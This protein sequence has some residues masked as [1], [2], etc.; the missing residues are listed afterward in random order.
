MHNFNI[1]LLRWEVLPITWLSVRSLYKGNEK[2]GSL[3]LC[4]LILALT[5]KSIPSQVTETNS[6]RLQY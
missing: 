3:A 2:K 5:S 6:L 1:D 4:P